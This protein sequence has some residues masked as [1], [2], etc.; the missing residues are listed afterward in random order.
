MK[1]KHNVVFQTN[2][3]DCVAC[4]VLHSNIIGN[5]DVYLKRYMKNTYTE[6]FSGMT[7]QFH[8]KHDRTTNQIQLTVG[9]YI[10]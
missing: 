2:C 8:N 5:Y 10:Q 9:I 7:R 6:T 4:F 1:T 3:S